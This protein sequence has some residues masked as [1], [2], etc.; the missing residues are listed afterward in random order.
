MVL[1][2]RY[3]HLRNEPL[4][5]LC[6]GAAQIDA[7][8]A[9]HCRDRNTALLRGFAALHTYAQHR[10]KEAGMRHLECGV[11]LIAGYVVGL[12]SNCLQVPL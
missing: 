7:A 6:L 5:M 1:L 3:R 2:H 12:P 8:L 11:H 4:L 10:G 9:R